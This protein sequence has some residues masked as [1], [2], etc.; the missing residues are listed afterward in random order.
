MRNGLNFELLMQLFFALEC[1]SIWKVPRPQVKVSDFKAKESEMLDNMVKRS[2]H[3]D[4]MKQCA[5]FQ[6]ASRLYRC[7]RFITKCLCSFAPMVA[8]SVAVIVL[9]LF[10]DPVSGWRIKMLNIFSASY[11]LFKLVIV[12][13]T[14]WAAKNYD[15]VLKDVES[16]KETTPP[17]DISSVK[18]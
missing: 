8:F 11:F 15:S 2:Q 14:I 17:E 16:V 9:A 18:C 12:L 1:L 5:R 4:E 7:L 3:W 6:R 13:L 10:C